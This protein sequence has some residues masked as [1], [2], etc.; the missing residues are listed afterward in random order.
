MESGIDAEGRFFGRLT[1][2]SRGSA[3]EASGSEPAGLKTQQS[4]RFPVFKPEVQLNLG[5]KPDVLLFVPLL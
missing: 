4:Q 5:R 1:K 2:L 3:P